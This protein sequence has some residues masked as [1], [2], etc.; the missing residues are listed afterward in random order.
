MSRRVK[1][2]AEPRYEVLNPRTQ[3]ELEAL[4][5]EMYPDNRIAAIEFQATLN[6]IDKAIIKSDLGIRNWY[7]PKE[8]AEYLWRRSNYH[9]IETDP[10]ASSL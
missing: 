1:F 10:Y 4:L 6:Q 5:L 8:L 7:T 3:E 9:A 2:R